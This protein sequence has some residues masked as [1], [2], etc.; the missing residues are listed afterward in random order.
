MMRCPFCGGMVDRKKVNY[1]YRKKEKYFI[2]RNV[3]ALVCSECG[4]RFFES[5]VVEKILSGKLEKTG[6]TI[7]TLE[8]IETTYPATS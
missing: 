4:E 6:T 1:E 8:E 5:E 7:R 2:V 3:P